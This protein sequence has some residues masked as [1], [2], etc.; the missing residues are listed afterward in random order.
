MS[1]VQ[2]IETFIKQK[3]NDLKN[4]KTTWD[5][6]CNEAPDKFMSLVKSGLKPTISRDSSAGPRTIGIT[7]TIES[8]MDDAKAYIEEI[9]EIIQNA[10]DKALDNADEITEKLKVLMIIR[11]SYN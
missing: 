8:H 5:D 4:I 3:R 2:N 7:M 1:E 10:R 11:L 6:L 9:R